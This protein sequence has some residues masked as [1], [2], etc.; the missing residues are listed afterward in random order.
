MGT[1]HSCC[2]H[3]LSPHI[4]SDVVVTILIEKIRSKIRLPLSERKWKLKRQ[5]TANSDLPSNN[6]TY[7]DLRS[8]HI[9]LQRLQVEYYHGQIC[10]YE[11]ELLSILFKESAYWNWPKINKKCKIL[12]IPNCF[13]VSSLY[14]KYTKRFFRNILW[15]KTN[16]L[17]KT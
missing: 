7:S 5:I 12:F 4:S 14:K 15:A 1:V 17:E 13:V 9:W 6:S 11:S 10:N 8:D 16:C 2:K 3:A